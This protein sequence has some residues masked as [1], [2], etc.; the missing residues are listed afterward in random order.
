MTTVSTT[1]ASAE[2]TNAAP[3][4]ADL[5]ALAEKLKATGGRVWI[6]NKADRPHVRVYWGEDYVRV[7]EDADGYEWDYVGSG[8][9]KRRK[10]TAK[11][12]AAL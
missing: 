9:I 1:E 5:E 3:F 6:A 8:S 10:C 11:V 4:A 7:Y 12:E 2:A